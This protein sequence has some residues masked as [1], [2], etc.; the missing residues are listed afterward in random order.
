MLSTDNECD[1]CFDPV[2]NVS[3]VSK[4][5]FKQLEVEPML[6]TP[7]TMLNGTFHNHP[8][9]NIC[10][11]CIPKLTKCPFCNIY[12]IELLSEGHA[13][14]YID[15]GYELEH[16]IMLLNIGFTHIQ[17]A[18]HH[19]IFVRNMECNIEMSIKC[20]QDWISDGSFSDNEIADYLYMYKTKREIKRWKK[21]GVVNHQ[22]LFEYIRR[23]SSLS[24]I[25]AWKK[26]NLSD[27][28]ILYCLKVNIQLIEARAWVK[29]EIYDFTPFVDMNISI[30]DVLEWR[31][32]DI[33][34][35]LILQYTVMGIRYTQ[36]P[37]IGFITR[38]KKFL[39]N[40]NPIHR[41]NPMYNDECI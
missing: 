11:K 33:A 2:S 30:N 29:N 38:I 8:N 37:R 6:H 25:L 18:E 19:R 22:I 13:R 4:H 39:K 12:M 7:H 10:N 31:K 34:D 41:R 9:N 27:E 3:N 32:R 1:I 15:L 5:T 21:A 40:L 23:G 14:I 24:T 35:D 17:L 28:T 20:F 36:F 26:N 16:V